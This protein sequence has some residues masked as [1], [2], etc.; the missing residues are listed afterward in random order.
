MFMKMDWS[1]SVVESILQ[2]KT[3]RMNCMCC[4]R[5]APTLFFRMTKHFTTII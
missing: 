4:I 2:V 1:R 3:G 5:D